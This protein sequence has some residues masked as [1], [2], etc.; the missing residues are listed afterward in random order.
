MLVFSFKQK[1]EVPFV[2]L[3]FRGTDMFSNLEGWKQE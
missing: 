2:Q 3:H 1:P